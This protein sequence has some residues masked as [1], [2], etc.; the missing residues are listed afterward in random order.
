LKTDNFPKKKKK[1]K[2]QTATV[3]I[4]KGKL[5]CTILTVKKEGNPTTG[6]KFVLQAQGIRFC[7]G[8]I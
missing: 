1:K 2:L 5:H 8:K 4:V 3:K 6:I 7:G